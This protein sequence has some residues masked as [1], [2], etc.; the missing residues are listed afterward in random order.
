MASELL[1]Q[2]RVINPV[3]QTDRIS[4]LLI[5][6]GVIRAIADQLTDYP[7]DTIPQDCRGLIAA[8]GL[9]DL[10]SQSGEPGFEERE[11]LDSLL[12]AATIGGF[13]RIAILP[14]T[15][16]AI[17]NPAMVAW[18]KDRHQTLRRSRPLSSSSLPASSSPLPHLHC[19]A[20]L[21]QKTQGQQMTELAELA[22]TEIVGFADGRSLNHL[23][24]VRRLLEYGQPLKK[25]IALWADDPN[26]AGDGVM[27]EGQESIMF[28]LPGIPAIA[29]TAPLAALL[30]C[31]AAINTPVHLMRVS[32]ARSVELIRAAKAQGVPITAS[33]TWMH[34]L[35]N[36]QVVGSYDPNLRVA[37][38][39]GNPADQQ[40]LQQA[41][42]AGILD[43]I[44][45]DHTPHSYEEKT[46]AFAEAPSGAIGLELAL[47]LLWQGL[48][49]SGQWSA[50]ELW[51]ALSTNPA[52]CL[53]QP[54]PTI[55]LN[56]PAELIL[57]N[58]DQTWTVDPA[59]LQ[60]RSQN[61]PWLGQTIQGRVV[62]LWAGRRSS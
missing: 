44:A 3:T 40:A 33:T 19:W 14:T 4:D 15:Q 32:T 20:A 6:D 53:Q 51:R 25:P 37:P 21:T 46:V 13:T 8:P 50:L 48:V 55:E 11:T 5:T 38:P 43:A 26:L 39:L 30:E 9:V 1:Q 18:L 54:P 49:A 58:P 16:P 35:L 28:G 17:D 24:L 42:Q 56:Q 34:L 27:R 41:V 60:S 45:I 7:T 10:Y 47:P 23:V 62:K 61:T 36:S 22:A 2:V 29:E 52:Q 57:F 59:S 12:Q 31:I